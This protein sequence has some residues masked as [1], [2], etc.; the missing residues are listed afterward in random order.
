MR[1]ARDSPGSRVNRS[2]DQSTE[3]PRAFIWAVM[4]A[5]D[6]SFQAQTSRR[7]VS[8]PRS[9]RVTPFFA[10]SRSTTIWVAIPAWSVPGSHSVLHPLIR[11]Q[12]IKISWIVKVSA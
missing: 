5:C 9:W 4:W 12:R 3:M 10:S 1:T 11:F 2:R 8:R 7:K 6:F